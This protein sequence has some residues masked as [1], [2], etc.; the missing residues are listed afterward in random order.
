VD[1]GFPKGNATNIESVDLRV[2]RARGELVRVDD[3][4]A[5]W[6]TVIRNVRQLVLGLPA[7]VAYEV[8]TLSR[9]DRAVLE[10][11]CWDALE[12]A[13]KG[14]GFEIPDPPDVEGDDG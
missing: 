7:A 13:A 5:R 10:K 8:P 2:R 3:V 12:E 11:I 14:V 4:R 1:T 6:G 9:A